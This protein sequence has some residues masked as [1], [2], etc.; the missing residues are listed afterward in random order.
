MERRTLGGFVGGLL[1]A[2]LAVTALAVVDAEAYPAGRGPYAPTEAWGGSIPARGSV[3]LS[4]TAARPFV[5]TDLVIQNEN[6]ACHA[7]VDVEDDTGRQLARVSLD[8]SIGDS[9]SHA[10]N[11]GLPIAALGSVTIS[12]DGTCVIAYIVSGHYLR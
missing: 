1:V 2:G 5:V 3:E 9:F 11:S 7:V 4:P 6:G 12:H 8:N 10:F